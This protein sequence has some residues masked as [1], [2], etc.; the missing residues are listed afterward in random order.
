MKHAQRLTEWLIDYGAIAVLAVL[1][2]LAWWQ[3]FSPV[4]R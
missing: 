3:T 1:T 4:V 2:W